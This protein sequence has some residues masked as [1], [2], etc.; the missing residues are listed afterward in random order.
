MP[1]GKRVLVISPEPSHPQNAGNRARVYSLIC[2]I[3][4]AGHDVHFLHASGKDAGNQ[5]AMHECW[6]ERFYSLPYI[7]P[8]PTLLR[9]LRGRWAKILGSRTSH[10]LDSLYNV[11]LDRFLQNLTREVTFDVV[12]V[13][14][15]FLSKALL[16]FD[17]RVLK[18]VDT[19]DVFS[20]RHQRM[21]ERGLEPNWHSLSP[22][23]EARGLNHSN[24]VVAISE[25][26]R[27]YLVEL[28]DRPVITVGHV[29]P[30]KKPTPPP[31]MSSAKILFLGS[32]NPMNA[33]GLEHFI[34]NVFPQVRSLHPD[35]ELL[36]AGGVCQHVPHCDGCTKLGQVENIGS[37]YSTASVV[38]NPMLFGTG[39][40]IKTVEAMGYAKPV[41]TTS[42]GARGL[43]EG[44]GTAFLVADTAPEMATCV[45]RILSDRDLSDRLAKGA[46]DFAVEW[47]TRN[48]DALRQ[49][50]DS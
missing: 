8:Q 11:S 40:S 6:G 46:C 20:N 23:E 22:K 24:I 7:K 49:V 13:E 48:L 27:D 15:V 14:Y 34:K 1:A 41:V 9:R 37:L 17:T 25:Q 47:N 16:C 5:R 36:I 21:A 42:V 31:S 30:L 43:N 35:V 38:I 29:V 32:A 3:Q 2:A 18:V 4:E 50:L 10:C 39:L 19:I 28:V 12:I 33:Q 44:A 45:S 26:D